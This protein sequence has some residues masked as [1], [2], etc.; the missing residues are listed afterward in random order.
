MLYLLV[1]TSTW[2][3]LAQRR[4]GQRWIVALRILIHE[5]EVKL[6]VPPVVIEE[7]DR[8]ESRVQAAMTSSIASRF[9]QIRKDIRTYGTE[10]DAHA[11]E[12]LEDLS[13]HIPLVGAM[14]TRNFKEI[15]EFLVAGQPVEASGLELERV[16]A[17][18]LSK[19]APFHSGK[20]STAD[21]M[22]LELYRTAMQNVHLSE[23]PHV[24]VTTNHTDFSR[25]DG[26]RREP[27]PD[28]QDAFNEPGSRYALGVDGLDACLRDHFG[29]AIEELFEETDFQEEP[30][31]LDEIV[32][33]ETE[34]FD[35]I[36]YHRS[37]QHDYRHEREGNDEELARIR[38]IAGPGR[39]RVEQT[40]TE[41]GQLGPYTD[42]ELGM[43]SGKMSALRWVL[44]SEWDFLDT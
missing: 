8:N 41:A 28:I 19:A 6:L 15:R 21:A 7:F 31:R 1:D 10:D 34:M 26:D 39:Q 22:I 17:A 14:T 23:H 44:G 16:V 18:G 2:L 36:W 11:V 42:F 29:D 35:R 43:L 33:A 25:A 3:D 9:K 40:Y 20:N 30:R 38:S 4:D 27:H 13:R 37:L 12:F 24:F 5:G 32:A